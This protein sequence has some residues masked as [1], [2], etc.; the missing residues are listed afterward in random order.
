ME[1][2][3]K[4]KWLKFFSV[5]GTI[6]LIVAMFFI[7]FF[8]GAYRVEEDKKIVAFADVGDAQYEWVLLGRTSSWYGSNVWSDGDN[9]YYS[10]STNQYVLDVSTHTWSTMTWN[11]VNV[12]NGA[13]IWSDG[14]DYYMSNGSTQLVLNKSTHTWSSMSWTGLRSFSGMQVWSDG[15]NIFWSSGSN[16]WVLDVS[17]HTWSSLAFGQSSLSGS[18][19]WNGGSNTYFS[20]NSNQLIFDS[21]T[22]TFSSKT[23]TPTSMSTLNGQMVFNY[24]NN[25]YYANGGLQYVLDVANDT[26]VESTLP[27]VNSS[28]NNYF[29][30]DSTLYYL[31]DNSFFGYIVPNS[32]SGSSEPQPNPGS[33][34]LITYFSS[35]R[36]PI[37]VDGLVYDSDAQSHTYIAPP[38]I[39][40][41]YFQFDAWTN[42]GEDEDLFMI[43]AELELPGMYGANTQ[44]YSLYFSLEDSYGSEDYSI[45]GNGSEVPYIIGSFDYNDN[46]NYKFW[47]EVSWS[48]LDNVN[49]QRVTF[50]SSVDDTNSIVT[51][52]VI[53]YV[54]SDTY[55]EFTFRHYFA[56]NSAITNDPNVLYAKG[57]G[58][59][60]YWLSTSF[61]S[62]SLYQSGYDAGYSNGVTAGS[63]SG[64]NSGYSTGRG[65][66]YN[67]GYGAGYN[68]GASDSQY[69][70]VSLIGA[71]FDA[72]V[73]GFTGMFNFDVLGV[74]LK[75]FLLGL[76]SVA[77]VITIIKF[78]MVK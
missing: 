46:S 66:G 16:A 21:S 47:V 27:L 78:V 45:V 72:P 50:T 75:D 8:I 60:T 20:N 52:S 34:T 4:S 39:G 36:I 5:I 13:Y 19:V 68:A 58:N 1:N 37:N 23:W 59:R 3:K 55:I 54:D 28:G 69:T 26:W 32:G 44:F 29:V 71:V 10:V 12:L 33:D 22:R 56:G 7:G 67:I 49:F 63:N 57:W 31:A 61:D 51:D 38:Y 53:C 18:F 43:Q 74:N 6:G 73:Q 9:L 62:D 11:G 77:I 17:T 41:A 70:F 48:N 15:S 14:V 35:S 42:I 65:E 40:N 24:D 2:E 76:F 30:F 25:T 64:Y